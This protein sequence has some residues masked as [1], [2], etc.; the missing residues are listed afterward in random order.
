MYTVNVYSVMVMCTVCSGAILQKADL[1]DYQMA[2]CNDGTT[3]AYFHDQVLYGRK[4]EYQLL[5]NT[6]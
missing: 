2:K 5:Q 6:P 3:A 4:I 1:T